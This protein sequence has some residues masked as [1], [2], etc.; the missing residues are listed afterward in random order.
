M[1]YHKRDLP[2]IIL[3]VTIFLLGE[4][5]ALLGKQ[6]KKSMIQ[7]DFSNGAAEALVGGILGILATLIMTLWKTWK[8]SKTIDS[9]K[10]YA[11]DIKTE[12]K[13]KT[14]AVQK[15]REHGNS[16]IDSY[17]DVRKFLY[18]IEGIYGKIKMVVSLPG[19]FP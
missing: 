13:E 1:A 11:G 18:S 5:A 19:G 10:E 15:N 14:K 4:C 7:I 17:P 16:K 8:D 12:V 3:P 9:V 2:I 6:G